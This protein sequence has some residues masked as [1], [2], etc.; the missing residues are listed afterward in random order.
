MK[1]NYLISLMFAITLTTSVGAQTN[2]YRQTVTNSINNKDA[3]FLLFPTRNNFIFLKLNTCNGEVYLVQ[4]S[5]DKP[6]SR[7]ET[8]IESYLYPLVSTK[9][10]SNGRFYLYPTANFFNYLLVDQIDGRV[11]QLQWGFKSADHKLIKIE[12]NRSQ[13]NEQTSFSDSIRVSDLEFKGNLAYKDHEL[14]S[15]IVYSK[16]G[17]MF[18]FVTDGRPFTVV[19]NHYNKKEYAYEFK[20]L[21]DIPDKLKH[22]CDDYGN[23]ITKEEFI[24][25]YPALIRIGKEFAKSLHLE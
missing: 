8:K 12:N 13:L 3:K 14:F 6:E 2:E 4:F 21:S 23:P 7:F 24:E 5:L 18:A 25:K 15:G 1:S 16:D 17:Q 19:V 10:E 11:W 22:F 9:E 20:E